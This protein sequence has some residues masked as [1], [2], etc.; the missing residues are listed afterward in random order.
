VIRISHGLSLLPISS[1]DLNRYC[2]QHCC[3]VCHCCQLLRSSFM[4]NRKHMATFTASQS[5]IPIVNGAFS[6]CDYG[7]EIEAWQ[8]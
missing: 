3:S 1:A 6:S 2:P 7:Q 8:L 4:F 5:S